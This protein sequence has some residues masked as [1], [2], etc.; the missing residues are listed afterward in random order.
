[1]IKSL[2]QSINVS[3]IASYSVNMFNLCEVF[4]SVKNTRRTSLN[5]V[6]LVSGLISSDTEGTEHS[7]CIV[8]S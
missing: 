5:S 3:N 6:L 8:E 1:M 4:V 7:V 2:S